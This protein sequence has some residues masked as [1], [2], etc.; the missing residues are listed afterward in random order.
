MT[1]IRLVVLFMICN[2]M[3]SLKAQRID[4]SFIFDGIKRDFIISKPSGAVPAG[5]YPIV[6]VLHGTT[7]DG[8]RFY[9]ISGWKELGEKEKIL[10]IY[11]SSLSYCVIADLGFKVNETKWNNGDLQSNKCPNVNQDFKDDVKFLKKIIDTVQSKFNI[12][13]KKIFLTGFS[14]G[15]VMSDKMIIEASDIFAA[16]ASSA[17]LIHALDSGKVKRFIPVWQT[18]GTADPNVAALNNGS[19]VPFN[20]SL[21][22]FYKTFS[23]TFLNCLNL[24]TTY[25]V[26]K[27]ANLYTF[28]FTKTKSPG[29]NNYFYYSFMKDLDHQYPNGDNYP[30]SDPVIFWEFFKQAVTT[31]PT[32]NISIP[33]RQIKSYPNPSHDIVMIELPDTWK[34]QPVRLEV[35]NAL[36]EKKLIKNWGLHN[37]PVTL[38]KF[39]LGTG[40]YVAVVSGGSQKALAKFV[41][42]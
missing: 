28:Q 32:D 38:N 29:Q 34:H 41:F 22:L 33:I 30:I 23:H 17:G 1:H 8:E 15:S 31:T 19:P 20:D 18:I 21:K 12:N 9:N 35:Y 6:M 39:E 42:D 13:T 3:L 40:I 25:T 16:I 27:S 37:S 11:P 36:G 26:T 10:T 24:D 14:N 7:G 5:G 4:A 2:A